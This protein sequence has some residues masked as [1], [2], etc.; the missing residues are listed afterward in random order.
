MKQ[1]TTTK[2]TTKTTKETAGTSRITADTIRRLRAETGAGIMEC[3]QALTAVGGDVEAAADYLRDN[4][5][6]TENTRSER[7]TLEGRV[8]TTSDE[9]GFAAVTLNCETDF[10]ARNQRFLDDG[11]RCAREALRHR[12][13]TRAARSAAESIIPG[14]IAV[15]KE[16][17]KIR[18][19][20]YLPVGNGE[21]LVT[22]IHNH[23][24]IAVAY[25]YTLDHPDPGAVL[26]YPD[27]TPASPEIPAE[28]SQLI[29]DI[30]LQIT[31]AEPLFIQ[32]STIPQAYLKEKEQEFHQEFNESGKPENLRTPIV[33][34]KMRKHLQTISL[35]DQPYI[36]DPGQ[37]TA[38]HMS[39]VLSKSGIRLTIR[40]MVRLAVS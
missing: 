3:R 27:S 35:L 26:G 16:N 11:A 22:Y 9:Q 36:K 30:A 37:T 6:V 10:A 5:A 29:T 17:I 34:G 38:A 14:L 32:P 24:R 12:E 1:E 40:N 33:S 31:A 15:I 25:T 39:S 8:F 13:D 18:E 4:A 23:G 21:R 19:I 7:E 20:R 2:T 28:V